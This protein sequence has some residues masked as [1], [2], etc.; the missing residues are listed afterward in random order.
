MFDLL[1]FYLKHAEDSILYGRADLRIIVVVVSLARI[2]FAPL[3]KDS[4]THQ[5]HGDQDPQLDLHDRRQRED[6]SPHLSLWL[7][8]KLGE[9]SAPEP[10]IVDVKLFQA[11]P[12]ETVDPECES[13]SS[14]ESGRDEDQVIVE[15][16]NQAS[17]EEGDREACRNV[18]SR[19]SNSAFRSQFEG[20]TPRRLTYDETPPPNDTIP[21]RSRALTSFNEPSESEPSHSGDEVFRLIVKEHPD[22]GSDQG[23]DDARQ[24]VEAS[25]HRTGWIGG[26]SG[27]DTGG[28]SVEMNKV[29]V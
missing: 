28:D 21:R 7:Y 15:R 24:G 3:R 18:V 16:G 27:F 23:G 22:A 11:G 12:G 8:P 10:E 19:F 1:E 5:E 17:D 2:L 9:Q 29:E 20:Q 4:P 14:D 25:E 6:P 13:G 26:R